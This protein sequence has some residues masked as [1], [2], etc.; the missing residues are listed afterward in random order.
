MSLSILWFILVAVLWTVYLIL[1]GFDFGVGMLLPFV[2]KGDRERTLTVR[3]I[4]PHWDGNE[5]WLL[6]AG[7]ATFAAF[8]EWY[9][10]MFSGMY[11]PLFLILA[12]L[13]VRVMA[14][15]WRSKIA[16]KRWRHAWDWAH[17]VSAWLVPLL[18]GVAFA[19]FV[20]GMRIEVVDVATGTIVDPTLVNQS[21]ATAT[22]QLTGGFF[23]LLTPYTI[24]G[25]L[26]VLA[27][28]LAHG[29][30]FL[31]LKT[32]GEVRERANAIAA[33]ASIGATVLA[34]AWLVWGQ[35]AYTTNVL[36]W[37]PLVVAALAI[38][39]SAALSQASLRREGWSFTA[40][41]VAI[42]GAV[43]WVFASMAPAVQ[44]SSINPA[45]SLT[46]DQASSTSATLGVMTIVAAC[47]VPVV[48]AYVL[49]SYW[50]FSARVGSEDVSI[51]TG[52]LMKKIRVG[53]SFL[54]G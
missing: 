24:L 27:I 37:I 34:A 19:N 47:L 36:A 25:G 7:G 4:G 6:T 3:T 42:A 50:V 12:C 46:I 17:T 29:A 21:L 1:E 18:L 38:I 44:K 40:S 15:E 43:A 39:A 22:H 52:L 8:P 13:I 11:I 48:L 26:A 2:A 31:A 9:A 5:V 33:P 20:Q 16:T 28:S 49:W 51:K 23:S 35:F 53:E 32:T 45:Y 10:T 41:S 14:L 30:Q 54:A